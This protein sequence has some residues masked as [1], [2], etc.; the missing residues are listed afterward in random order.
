[1]SLQVD[2]SLLSSQRSSYNS[3]TQPQLEHH[4]SDRIYN[5]L[6][7]LLQTQSIKQQFSLILVIEIE[8]SPMKVSSK[9]AFNS[10][11]NDLGLEPIELAQRSM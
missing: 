4:H 6:I 11:F 8:P 10:L 2:S 9:K 7:V 3:C 5:L 1:M